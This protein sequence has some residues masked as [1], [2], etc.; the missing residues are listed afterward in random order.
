MKLF[1]AQHCIQGCRSQ[2][3]T[4]T[5]GFYGDTNP[6]SYLLS[7]YLTEI[8]VINKF[9]NQQW[10]FFNLF[11]IWEISQIEFYLKHKAEILFK[12]KAE[13]LIKLWRRPSIMTSLSHMCFVLLS[14]IL[15]I[16]MSTFSSWRC[17]LK[18][19]NLTYWSS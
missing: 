4:S 15:F 2:G 17:D 1:R 16:T 7:T 3:F 10:N 14:F 9:P 18:M 19:L 6:T 5:V 8:K 11:A 12:S 13:D